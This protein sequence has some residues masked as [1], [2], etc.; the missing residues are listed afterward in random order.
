MKAHYGY[1]FAACVFAFLWGYQVSQND[2]IRASLDVFLVGSYV[3]GA[4][5]A[6]RGGAA[7]GET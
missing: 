6:R 5:K 2:A 7:G 1:A 4:E 3:W